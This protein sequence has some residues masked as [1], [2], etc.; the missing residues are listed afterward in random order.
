MNST[1]SPASSS[2]VE[3]LPVKSTTPQLT[4]SKSFG[5]RWIDFV[6]SGLRLFL[7]ESKVKKVWRLIYRYNP[8]RTG[9][10]LIGGLLLTLSMQSRTLAQKGE[11]W[12]NEQN[13]VE[14]LFG[15][16]LTGADDFI[17]MI[18]GSGRF[19]AFGFGIG[20]VLYGVYD[21]IT[22]RGSNWHIWVG[23]G[24]TLSIGAVFM[25]VWGGLIFGT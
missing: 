17:S 21:G 7:P 25:S 15:D 14:T 18:F 5:E 16:H 9:G 6:D 19:M 12:E 1:A 3:L 8:W 24:S 2:V 22:N 23:I 13:A 4:K 10:V 11:L 20:F